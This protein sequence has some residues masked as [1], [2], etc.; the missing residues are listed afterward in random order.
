MVPSTTVAVATWEP[1]LLEVCDLVFRGLLPKG[2]LVGV[3]RLVEGQGLECVLD[4]LRDACVGKLPLHG[5]ALKA[6]DRDWR[7]AEGAD[8]VP[9]AN[10]LDENPLGFPTGVYLCLIFTGVVVLLFGFLA[11]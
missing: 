8:R 11:Y 10:S 6:E 4:V 3:A 5:R 1:D 7:D 2:R 9:N